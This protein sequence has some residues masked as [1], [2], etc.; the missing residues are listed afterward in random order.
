MDWVVGKE[1]WREWYCF[2]FNGGGYCNIVH[3]TRAAALAHC[4][5]LN[6]KKGT[7]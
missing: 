1:S 7:K 5:R 3:L 2:D 4:K 6:A